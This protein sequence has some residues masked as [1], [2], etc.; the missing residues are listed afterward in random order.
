MKKIVSL[1]LILFLCFPI[2]SF[3]IDVKEEFAEAGNSAE[4]LTYLICGLDES[5]S[6]TDTM[7][8]VS[9]DRSRDRIDFIHI[10]RD[11]FLMT[12]TGAQKI[13][14]I[15]PGKL[16]AGSDISKAIAD[17]ASGV[18]EALSI[19]LDGYFV[20]TVSAIEKIIDIFG[21]VEIELP[22]EIKGTDSS[23]TTI[24]LN[25]GKNRL[26]GREASVFLRHRKS[27]A[28]GDLARCDAQKIFLSAFLSEVERN[29]TIDTGLR[30]LA[31]R[32]EGMY[33]NVDFMPLVGFAV[34]NRGRIMKASKNFST[35]PGKAI[36][37]NSTSYYVLNKAASEK[38][39]LETGLFSGNEV[40]DP[41]GIFTDASIEKIN[42]IYLSESIKYDLYDSNEVK[43]I[44]I[45]RK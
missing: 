20:Y 36:V 22:F 17:L 18:A 3:V 44:K 26:S 14:S 33:S 29:M 25:E 15:L 7:L 8:L 41:A 45:I 21:G 13:N 12:S 16:Q 2:S 11:T 27:Y 34:K 5:A 38:L 19:R 6:N 1:F 23:G 28:L 35:I 24:S 10:P 32:G 37:H 4:R 31:L 40:F 30:L 39:F 42:D 9:Y 43:D